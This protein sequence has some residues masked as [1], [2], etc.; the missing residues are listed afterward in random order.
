MRRDA[1]DSRANTML[2]IH[3]NKQAQY[4]LAEQHLRKAVE[5]LSQ[6]YTRPRDAEANYQLGLALRA[7]HREAEAYD[8]FYRATW[9]QAFHAAA[10]Y[11][12]AELSCIRADF[13]Q[14]LAQI[15]R[16]LSTNAQNTKALNAKVGRSP[17][18]G[19]T[20]HDAEAGPG[21]PCSRSIR[22]TSGP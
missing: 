12:L 9:D 14:A 2:G 16:S 8:S 19:T 17:Q 18:T 5:R 4:E 13:A 21:G 3:Y 11:Q 7:Q 6:G 1:G 20:L 10:Y 15:D 22:S